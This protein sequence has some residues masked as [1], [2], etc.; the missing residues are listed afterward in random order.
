M[1]AL[2][3]L[4]VLLVAFLVVGCG[5]LTVRYVRRRRGGVQPWKNPYAAPY[6]DIYRGGSSPIPPPST[7]CERSADGDP[8]AR[9]SDDVDGHPQ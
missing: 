2:L 5:V 7:V 3:V 4:K 9:G 1:T 8:A 6:L